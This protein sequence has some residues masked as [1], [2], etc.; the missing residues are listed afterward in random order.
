M[1]RDLKFRVWTSFGMFHNVSVHDGDTF[2]MSNDDFYKTAKKPKDQEEDDWEDLLCEYNFM[3]CGEDWLQGD[4][5]IMQ[6]TGLKDKNKKDIYEGDIVRCGYGLGKVIFSSGCFWVQ[7]IDDR[8]A[9]MEWLHSRKGTY[10]RTEDELFEIEGNIFENEELVN[11][12]ASAG[13]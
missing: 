2:G 5:Q 13:N 8:E 6:F 10:I 1:K 4:G 11:I 3:D 12:G 9:Y 7:W